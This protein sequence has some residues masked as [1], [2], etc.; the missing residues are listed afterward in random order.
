M[1]VK[2]RIPTKNV[3]QY[4]WMIPV[5]GKQKAKKTGS[6]IFNNSYNKKVAQ[7]PRE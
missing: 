3:G 1:S 7:L 5:S 6:V 4:S 2:I